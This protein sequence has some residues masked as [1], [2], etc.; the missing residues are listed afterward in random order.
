MIQQLLRRPVWLVALAA[1]TLIFLFAVANKQP[2]S[3]SSRGF[4]QQG[5]GALD[6]INN[7]TLGVRQ[8]FFYFRFTTLAVAVCS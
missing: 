7:S 3:T 4:S 5:Y 8:I 6:N 1:C 2:L